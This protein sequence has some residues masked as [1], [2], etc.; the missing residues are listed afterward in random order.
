MEPGKV[1]RALISVSNSVLNSFGT[2][3]AAARYPAVPNMN[4][5]A[6]LFAAKRLLR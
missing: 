4:C 1:T 2:F 5:R 6:R 3:A